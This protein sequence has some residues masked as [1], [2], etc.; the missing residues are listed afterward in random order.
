MDLKNM[1]YPISVCVPMYNAS[2]YLR[3]CIDS[4]LGQTFSDFEL[5][6]IDDGSTDESRNI[7]R[8]YQDVRIRL[9]ESS[10]DYIN[11]LNLLLK[12]AKGKYIARMDADDIMLPDRLEVQYNYMEAHP[13]T[14]I[15]GC[16]MYYMGE[17]EKLY[18]NQGVVTIQD[19]LSGNYI[20][21]PTVMM[22]RD[23]IRKAN[24]WYDEKFKY[25]EDYHFWV[26]AAMSGL[27]MLN[28]DKPVLKY[29]S[30]SGQ[31]SSVHSLEQYKRTKE[32]QS[33]LSCWLA[34]DEAIWADSHP[35]NIPDTSNKLT[36][37]IPFLNEKEEVGNTVRSIRA[38]VGEQ[39][40]IIVINDQSNDGYNYR[41]DILPYHVTYVYP[42]A[43]LI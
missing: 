19:L 1:S 15:L 17:S 41:K 3:E 43:E 11:T 10:H 31:T 37:I 20:A 40:D 28:L 30:S 27:Y 8:S 21:N 9:I 34:R 25:A 16:S 5:L 26:Q 7:I 32:V 6:I 14:D 36:V 2:A 18:A 13:E 39:V 4:I 35:C 23:S 22:R 42:L 38:T 33:V 29:R 12:E 24:I